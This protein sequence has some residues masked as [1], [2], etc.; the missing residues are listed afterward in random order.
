[1]D[2]SAVGTECTARIRQTGQRWA[3]LGHRRVSDRHRGRRVRRGL[4]VFFA[5]GRESVTSSRS[6]IPS[7]PLD[8]FGSLAVSF[9]SD[10]LAAFLLSSSPEPEPPAP[11][12]RARAE[13]RTTTTSA[14]RTARMNHPGYRP[15]HVQLLRLQRAMSSS[16]EHVDTDYSHSPRTPWQLYC[17]EPV[18]R[19]LLALV[20]NGPVEAGRT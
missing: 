20:T 9:R 2:A 13:S 17:A 15:V 3:L 8:V 7:S 14:T 18:L 16:S 1:M 4:L 19:L 5:V 11:R 10:S 12:P 6:G